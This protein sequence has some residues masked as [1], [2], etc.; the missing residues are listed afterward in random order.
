MSKD[1]GFKIKGRVMEKTD[2]H[3][4]NKNKDYFTLNLFVGGSRNMAVSVDRNTYT[5]VKEGQEIELPVTVSPTVRNGYG[6]LFIN[7]KNQ[8]NDAAESKKAS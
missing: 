6:S 5:A 3:S 1:L 7:M 8:M 4:D 2:F